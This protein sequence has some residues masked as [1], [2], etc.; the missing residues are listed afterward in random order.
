MPRARGPGGRARGPDGHAPACEPGEHGQPHVR[1]STFQRP[2]EEGVLTRG[3]CRLLESMVEQEDL[4]HSIVRPFVSA[5]H[6]HARTLLESGTLISG[7]LI[8]WT[9]RS[10]NPPSSRKPAHP[11]PSRLTCATRSARPRRATARS[12][13]TTTSSCSRARSTSRSRS[14]RRPVRTNQVTPRRTSGCSWE[15]SW[16]TSASSRGRS[17]HG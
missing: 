15:R 3:M 2:M 8:G 6:A 13:R 9:V 11:V 4:T 16:S 5:Y 12:S 17:R 10:I 7:T 14:R 1:F